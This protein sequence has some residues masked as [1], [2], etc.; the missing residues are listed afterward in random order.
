MSPEH[1]ILTPEE[2]A[3]VHEHTVLDRHRLMEQFHNL[4]QQTETALVGM[5]VFLATEV[6]FFGTLFI[7]LAVYRYRDNAAFTTASEQLNW[8]IGGINTVVLLTSSLTMAL[9]VHYSKLGNR[10]ALVWYLLATGVLGLAFMG[11]KAREYYED[12]EENLVPGTR[13]FDDAEWLERGPRTADNPTANLTPAQVPHVKQFLLLYWIMTGLHAF[14]VLI[15]IV[16]L[17]GLAALAKRG[18]YS[19]VYYTPVEVTGLYWHFVDLVWIFLFPMLYLVG[20]HNM[21]EI[22]F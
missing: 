22:H 18:H 10:R 20:L 2:Q 7:S 11:F 16:V 14:H 4:E 8:M 17:F 19:P 12:F 5:W 6:L 13:F 9:A 15:G 3:V 1:S 21:S